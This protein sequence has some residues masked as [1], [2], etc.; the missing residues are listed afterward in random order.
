MGLEIDLPY[1]CKLDLMKK[2]KKFAFVN[3]CDEIDGMSN[4]KKR[5]KKF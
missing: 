3:E 2:K 1:L 4:T 5:N